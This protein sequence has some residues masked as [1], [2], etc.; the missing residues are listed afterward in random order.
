LKEVIWKSL[1]AERTGKEV[2]L[3]EH[4]AVVA[5]QMEE[6]TRR[7]DEARG[8]LLKIQPDSAQPNA[9]TTN[10]KDGH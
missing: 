7:K 2:Q 10:A 8:K 1:E 4:Q 9:T 5:L 3:Q 6:N